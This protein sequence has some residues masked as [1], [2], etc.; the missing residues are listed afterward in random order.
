MALTSKYSTIGSWAIAISRALSARGID[1]YRVFDSAGLI[2]DGIEA[3]PESR[4]AIEKMTLLW[5][6]AEQATGT[7]EFGLTVG[8]YAYPMHFRS[9]GLLMMTSAT[10]AQAF[11]TLPNYSAL[12]SNSASIKLQRT[13]DRVGFTITPLPGV[14][15]S[16]MSIDAFF[17]TLVHHGEL[18]LGHGKF[19]LSVELMRAE[20]KDIAPWHSCFSCPIS[21]NKLENCL[22]MDRG[23]LEQ[24]TVMGNPK[25]AA[26]NEIKVRD[27]LDKMQ[28]LKWQEK[29][30]QAIHAMLVS[31]EPTAHKVAQVYNI[32]ERTLRRKLG[33]EG[34]SFRELL[35]QKRKEL[36]YHYLINTEASIT[37]VSDKLGYTSLSN[38][39]RAF[40]RW[41]GTS[42]A[43]FRY[44]SKI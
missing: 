10:L 1:A 18:I 41:Y 24:S 23:M 35:Q 32:S 21:F 28:A 7:P 19:V 44:R 2:L 22:W 26:Q 12:V 9:L 39:S 5:S 42:P 34:A 14:E 4:I 38:F 43:S 13:P 37:L 31:G 6:L 33:S 11:E 8:Q 17:A 36:A 40:H 20:P 29:V 3:A 16:P 27:Y 15:I 30:S 25:L